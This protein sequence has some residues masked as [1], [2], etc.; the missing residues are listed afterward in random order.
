MAKQILVDQDYN[1]V[2][3][4][5]NLPDPVSGQDAAT[6]AYVDSAVEG[7]AWKDSVRVASTSNINLASPGTTI[8]GITMSNGDRFLARGQSTGSQN[9]IYIFNGS[10]T[11]ATRSLDANTSNELEQATTTVEEGTDAGTTFRQTTVNFT[12]GSGTV[13]W[14]TF[15]T[16]APSSSESTAGVLEIA[17][18]GETDTGTDDARAVTPLKLATWSGR[19]KKASVL[20]GDGSATQYTVTHNF[21]TR[22]VMVEVYRNSGSY[23]TII[24]DVTRSS[25]NAVQLTFSSAPASNAFKVVVFA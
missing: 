3:K 7:I 4:I 6:K 8:D 11:A 16:A 9:G 1:N 24:C 19:V 5:T 17:T 15:G 23:D 12:L 14:A 13:T 20:I 10:G 2:S 18:Q 22:D 25:T 21:G